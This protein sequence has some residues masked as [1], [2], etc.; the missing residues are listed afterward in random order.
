MYTQFI[1]K[2]DTAVEGAETAT[3]VLVAVTARY[4]SRGNSHAKYCNN[5]NIGFNLEFGI[6]T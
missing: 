1:H 5:I 6:W 2:M 4:R 3:S